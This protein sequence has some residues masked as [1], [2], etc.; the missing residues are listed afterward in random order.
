[1]S[2]KITNPMIPFEN[3]WVA[4]TPDSR[5]VIASGRTIKE[6]EKK[7]DKIGNH[8]A[9]FTKVLPFGQFYSPQCE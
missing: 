8:E 2:K 6:L 1:M 7:V 5:G 3:M 4:L 9:V